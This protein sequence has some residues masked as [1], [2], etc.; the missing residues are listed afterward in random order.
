MT[1]P[2]INQSRF[3]EK[4]VIGTAGKGGVLSI[5]FDSAD[6]NESIRRVE[7]AIQVRDF[8]LTKLAAGGART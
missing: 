4:I 6:Y 1:E 8:L 7:V 5:S 2:V 3:Q